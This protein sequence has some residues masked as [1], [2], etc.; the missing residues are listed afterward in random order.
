MKNQDWIRFLNIIKKF[1]VTD[2][3]L[4]YKPV[5]I[6]YGE[7]FYTVKKRYFIDLYMVYNSQKRLVYTLAGFSNTSHD[8]QV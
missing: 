6:I 8:L 7:R 1:D 2:I 5:K 3:I 4:K